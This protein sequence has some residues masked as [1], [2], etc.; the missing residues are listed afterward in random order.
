MKDVS[1]PHSEEFLLHCTG[2]ALDE[3]LESFTYKSKPLSNKQHLPTMTRRLASQA[4]YQDQSHNEAITRC[5]RQAADFVDNLIEALKSRRKKNNSEI[6]T[7]A[8]KAFDLQEIYRRDG[9]N[10]EGRTAFIKYAEAAMNVDFLEHYSLDELEFQYNEFQSS[11][12]EAKQE[13]YDGCSFSRKREFEKELYNKLPSNSSSFPEINHLLAIATVRLANESQCESIGSVIGSLY[14][15][16]KVEKVSKELFIAWNGP[17]P[18]NQCNTLLKDALC[19]RF[20]GGPEKWHFL[21]VTRRIDL[22]K[23]Y[24]FKSSKVVDRLNKTSSR[25]NYDYDYK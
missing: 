20:G 9:G 17:P 8:S 6:L 25:I 1:S 18:F 10:Q 24:F 22:L 16:L 11:V 14:G 2:E 23:T 12:R 13:W 21:R 15:S 3:I 4:K 5:R 19:L 7:L